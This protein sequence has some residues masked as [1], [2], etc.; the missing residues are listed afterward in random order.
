VIGDNAWLDA[1]VRVGAVMGLMTFM[2]LLLI[3]LERKVVGRIQMRL[4]PM[5]TG[6]FGILQTPADMV[7]LLTKEDLRPA[8]ADRWVFE[9]APIAAFVPVFL[10]LMAL[11]FT[12]SWGVRVLDLGL[13]YF[14]AV[15]SLS[16]LGY[17]MAGLASD[18]KYALLGAMRT[19]AQLISYEV[20]LV[21][22]VLALAM[23][24]GSLNLVEIVEA[25]GRVPFIVWQPLGFF[26]L[27]VG[28]YAEMFRRPF[29]IPIGESELVGGPWIEYSGIRWGMMFALP[30]FA[31]LFG[32][33]VLAA[34]LFLGGWD[35]PLGRELGWAW[36][37]F[38][39]S[40]KTSFLILMAFWIGATFPRLRIDQLMAFCWKILLPMA[41]LQVFLNGLVLVYDWPD[42]TLL[43]TSGLA[44]VALIYIVYL[45]TRLPPSVR[46]LTSTALG[47][48]AQARPVA[49]GG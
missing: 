8:S 7:K 1:L 35:W 46:A 26:I 45:A 16:I 29:D 14:I 18:S 36:Q 48:T 30:E 10:T 21:L 44:L 47:G 2:A 12:D 34:L 22:A 25:Q 41:F 33:S 13:F 6:P 3:Y 37:L 27:I 49:G 19:A 28:S 42:W 20:P 39:I 5:R 31:N 4:G 11:P 17:I 23:V 15:G 24:A 9:L 40:I 43:L 32:F 38:L